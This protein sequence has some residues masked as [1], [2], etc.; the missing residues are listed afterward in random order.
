V[1][2]NFLNPWVNEATKSKLNWPW[3]KKF[4]QNCIYHII[5]P[6][7]PP[8]LFTMANNIPALRIITLTYN[9]I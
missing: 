5:H 9:T 4:K 2:F 3:K 1:A 6:E 7:T 8:V